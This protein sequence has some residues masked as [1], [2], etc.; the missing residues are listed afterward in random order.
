M[1]TQTKIANFSGSLDYTE[2][3]QTWIVNPGVTGQAI[4]DGNVVV[5]N[6]PGSRLENHGT[7][8][9]NTAA[10]LFLELNGLVADG[11]SVLNGVGASITGS[12]AI[13]FLNCTGAIAD[14]QGSLTSTSFYGVHFSES[15]DATLVNSGSIF[16]KLAGI[17]I[18]ST[19]GAEI[20]NTGFINSEQYGLWVLDGVGFRPEVTNSGTISGSLASIVVENGDKVLLLNSG[21]LNGDVLCKSIGQNDKIVNSGLIN[22]DVF[23]GPGNDTYDGTGGKSGTVF[24]EDGNDR[25]IGGPSSDTF[26]GGLGKDHFV[27]AATP[28][29]VSNVDAITDFDV[30]KDIIELDNAIFG[31]LKKTGVLKDTFFDIGKKADD[32]KDFILYDKKTGFLAYDADGSK[33][34]AEAIVL[35]KLEDHLKLKADDFLVI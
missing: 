13:A 31:K 34:G 6:Q 16:G 21:T 19:N 32:K 15:A 5:T 23:L 7:L 14:N 26:T 17:R 33:K 9:A 4:A 20:T 22:G 27:F 8:I 28:N 18:A 25:I 2:P 30:K 12:V 24:G 35:A 10:V 29:A 1:T 3:N 11:S